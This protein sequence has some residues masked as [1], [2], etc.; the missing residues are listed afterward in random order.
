MQTFGKQD[1]SL[2]PAFAE[3][4]LCLKKDWLLRPYELRFQRAH[5]QVL[6]SA[7]IIASGEL[8][9]INRGLDA[10]A[11]ACAPA[12]CPDNDAEDMHTWLEAVLPVR[13]RGG[14]GRG[15]VGRSRECG[16]RGGV[17]GPI[18]D[19][20]QRITRGDPPRG[21]GTA[22]RSGQITDPRK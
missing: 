18:P 11:E 14:G 2:D 15:A 7:G 8:A 10:G 1:S 13:H 4:N 6:R 3:T 16:R 19:D 21:G 5:G 9:D 12:W 20:R 17:R 22:P